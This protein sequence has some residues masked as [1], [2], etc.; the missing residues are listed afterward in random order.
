[1]VICLDEAQ[2][3][4]VFVFT[5]KWSFQCVSERFQ[6]TL[7]LGKPFMMF[8]YRHQA[9]RPRAKKRD[10]GIREKSKEARKK[11]NR[12]IGRKQ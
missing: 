5:D 1:M 12:R 11:R 3:A 7:V 6:G 9:G 8:L 4:F 10:D 2:T